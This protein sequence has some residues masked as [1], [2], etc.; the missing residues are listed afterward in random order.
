MKVEIQETGGKLYHDF[1]ES[2][3]GNME[4]LSFIQDLASDCTP[5]DLEV[6]LL[7]I[8]KLCL[9]DTD[10]LSKDSCVPLES[11]PYTSAHEELSQPVEITG[12]RK[13]RKTTRDKAARKAEMEK[14][15]AIKQMRNRIS[16]Q[17]S[18]DRKKQEMEE[19]R[20]ETEKLKQENYDLK[21]QLQAAKSEL[22]LLR[23]MTVKVKETKS[24]EKKEGRKNSR[25][26][27][28]LAA[29]LFGY[30]CMTSCITPLVKNFE[31]PETVQKLTMERV[32]VEVPLLAT[33]DQL[34]SAQKARRRY[35]E[36]ASHVYQ[37]PKV[38]ARDPIIL[39]AKSKELAT[40]IVTMD[41]I[42]QGE[43]MDLADKIYT[44]GPGITVDQ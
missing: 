23:Q 18:R 39:L 1:N 17:R 32:K 4:E 37:H 43:R 8:P 9:P 7:P 27:F 29:L 31:L 2:V 24:R 14:K 28:L 12:K 40:G 22:E 30:V 33:E 15:K 38:E 13:P 25:A 42:K 5:G 44:N 34:T 41:S 36:E 26:K 3:Y 35:I 6:E 16:A 19:L 10:C 20:D 21:S 11:P